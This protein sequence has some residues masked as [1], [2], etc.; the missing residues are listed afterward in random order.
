MLKLLKLTIIIKTCLLIA[1]LFALPLN[2]TGIVN[3]VNSDSDT[4]A[5]PQTDYPGQDAQY[6][7]DFTHNDS[8]DGHTGS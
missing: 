2:D 6:G 8:S 7:R 3:C 5:C 1:P 4:N